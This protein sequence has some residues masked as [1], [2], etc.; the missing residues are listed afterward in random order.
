M[1]TALILLLLTVSFFLVLPTANAQQSPR[2]IR[3]TICPECGTINS[4]DAV[5][6]GNCGTRLQF[7]R[8]VN[9]VDEAIFYQLVR[10]LRD[11]TDAQG[12]LVDVS[13]LRTAAA[14]L[15]PRVSQ[16]LL[17]GGF[18][19]RRAAHVDTVTT[20]YA[21]RSDAETAVVKAKLTP[22]DATISVVIISIMVLIIG[23]IIL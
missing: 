22:E 4:A 17:A 20:A 21:A 18:S 5:F 15:A 8:P 23:A 1:R 12:N 9:Q 6:C 3:S 10:A 11:S 2:G 19:V 7:L 14:A 16:D 13:T